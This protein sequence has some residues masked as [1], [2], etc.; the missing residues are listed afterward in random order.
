MK[1][2]RVWIILYYLLIICSCTKDDSL[3]YYEL[4]KNESFEKECIIEPLL[5]T[6]SLIVLHWNIG[7]FSK[8]LV[9]NS[10]VAGE[11]MDSIIVEYHS[12]FEKLSPDIVS[13]NEYSQVLYADR[14]TILFSRDILFNDYNY[15]YIGLQNT[16]SC[17]ALFLDFPLLGVRYNKFNCNESLVLSLPSYIQAE[18]YYYISSRFTWED[19]TINIV[20]THLAYSPDNPKVVVNQIREL[21]KFFESEDYVIMCGDWNGAPDVYKLFEKKGY[22]LLNCGDNGRYVTHPLSSKYLD[23][24]VVKGLAMSNVNVLETNLSDH[25]PISCTVRLKE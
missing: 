11:D 24:I 16:Y 9:T 5:D 13:I 10:L 22:E 3:Y 23:N 8:G 15:A 14:D 7:H 18:D 6:D 21:L 19:K 1:S 2:I 25:Y 20:S 4:I 12:I 17:N